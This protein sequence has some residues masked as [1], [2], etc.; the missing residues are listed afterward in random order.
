MAIQAGRTGHVD[1]PASVASPTT[2]N[3]GHAL[4]RRPLLGYLCVPPEMPDKE[5]EHLRRRLTDFASCEGFTLLRV[6]VDRRHLHTSGF[7]ALFYALARGEARH[8]VVP[9]LRHFARFRSIQLVIKELIEDETG[10]RVL[11]LYPSFEESA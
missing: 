4:D 11:V 3:S 1:I 9:A 7:T 2:T 6:F 10:A 8:V 5:L